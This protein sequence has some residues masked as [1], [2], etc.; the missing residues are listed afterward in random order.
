MKTIGVI[1]GLGPQATMDFEARLH[2]VAQRLIPQRHNTGH[3]PLIVAYVRKV[4]MVFDEQGE[5]HA[6]PALLEAAQKIGPLVD[7]LVM[8]S[9]TPHLFQH[10]IEQASGTKILSMIDA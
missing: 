4:P 3:P 10:E 6:A 8:A 5:A 9:N 7:V 1:G 2:A